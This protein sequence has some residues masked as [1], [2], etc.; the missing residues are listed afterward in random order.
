VRVRAVAEL[1][2]SGVPVTRLSFGGSALADDDVSEAQAHAA[3]TAA[4]DAGIRYFDT[5]PL[6]ALGR[7]ER[8]LGA[9]LQG[10]PRSSFTVST[11][12]GRLLRPDGWSWDFSGDGVRRSLDGS[13]ERLGLDAVDVA[14]LHDPDEQWE[15]ASQEAYA[16]LH[17]LRQ[18]GVVRAIGVGMNQS[19][20]LTDFVSRCELDCVIVAGRWTL[21]D[22]EAG[23]ALLPLCASRNISVIAAGVFN[24][25]LLADPDAADATYDYRPADAAVRRRA[26]DLRTALA[27]RGVPLA[28]AALQFPTTHPAVV[29]VLVGCRSAAEVRHNAAMF[30]LPLP[31]DSFEDTRA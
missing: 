5:A 6:Y 27:D 10:R 16:V 28:A 19:T 23:R 1:G 20:M 14:L 25:G 9:A 29:S 3:V 13:L 4:W 7:A 18:Q 17:E 24:S 12:V 26:L 21:L 2:T 30:Q 31:A 22:R 8:R 11:K 15:Q